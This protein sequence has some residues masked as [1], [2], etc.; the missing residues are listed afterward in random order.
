MLSRTLV[1]TVFLTGL[2]LQSS[3]VVAQ[4]PVVWRQVSAPALLDLQFEPTSPT[5]IDE[6]RLV[7]I[8]GGEHQLVVV[9]DPAR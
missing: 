1:P 4:G 9:N 3:I 8:D 6:Q 7:L 2:C 5:W